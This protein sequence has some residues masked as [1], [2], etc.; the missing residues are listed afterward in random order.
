[1]QRQILFGIG[2]LIVGLIVGF[3]GAN[4]INRS[5]VL[6][7]QIT[8]NQPDT[9]SML[10]HGTKDS[11]KGQ[12]TMLAD[13]QEKL[14]K[15]KNEPDNFA[16]QMQAGDMYA[17]IGR[18]D[19]AVKF[20]EAGIKL[21][22]AD[23][24]ANLV[25]ANSYF[26]SKQFEKAEKYYTKFLEINPKDVN[27]RSDLATTLVEKQNPEYERAVKEFQTAL[28]INPNHEPTLY[29]LAIAYSRQGKT[30]DAQK[31]IARLEQANPS[32][33]LIDKLKQNI[34]KQK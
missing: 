19:E 4:S 29:N 25:I 33:Q 5:A 17:Q 23:A 12:G 20:Y 14:E 32:S 8:Q 10:D 22:P 27:A 24:Q 34:V 13:V 11:P 15:A 3:W 16:A 21:N 28:E 1:M 6:Q 26:D 2:G 9:A 31:T 18:Y 30:E 7:P